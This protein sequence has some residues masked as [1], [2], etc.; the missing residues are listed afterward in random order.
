MWMF[1][2]FK[3]SF[4]CVWMDRCSWVINVNGLL[5]YQTQKQLNNKCHFED[6]SPWER[7]CP[8]LDK[9]TKQ[10]AK[11]KK[12]RNQ[13]TDISSFAEDKLI[14]HSAHECKRSDPKSVSLLRNIST[15]R[16]LTIECVEN[17][18]LLRNCARRELIVALLE[19]T[20]FEYLRCKF[21]WCS[22]IL[23]YLSSLDSLLWSV[24]WLIGHPLMFFPFCFLCCHFMTVLFF[25]DIL[26][27]YYA[28]IDCW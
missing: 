24:Y 13:G 25:S 22:R 16:S 12:N 9:H 2:S 21:L 4:R 23:C 14:D 19:L 27:V 1:V 5:L 7:K 10:Q 26:S 6:N 28:Y 3:T 20:S 18:W 8:V 17:V 15:S 11:K